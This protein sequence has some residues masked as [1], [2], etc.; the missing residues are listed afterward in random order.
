M[1]P[2]QALADVAHYIQHL[3]E[4]VEGSADSP[5]ILIGSHYSGTLATWFRAKY[6]HLA[7]AA[8]ASSAPLLSVID[9]FQFKE[10]AGESFRS[11]GGPEC[12]D[13]IES[14]FAEMEY[15]A[16][17]GQLERLGEIFNLCDPIENPNDIATFFAVVAEFYSIL[18]QTAT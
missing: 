4:T 13:A 9:H 14:G 15:M 6:P 12:Y 11:V 8:W 2:D 10:F 1:T 16:A 3:K 18:P 17:N 5:V 7:L